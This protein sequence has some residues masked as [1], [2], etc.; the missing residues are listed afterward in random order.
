VLRTLALVAVVAACGQ[1][2]TPSNSKA[3]EA[4]ISIALYRHGDTSYG[5]VDDR[6]WVDIA[7]SSILLGNID[8]GAALASLVIESTDPSVRIGPCTRERMPDERDLP[9]APSPTREAYEEARRRA[10]LEAERDMPRRYRTRRPTPAVR[11]PAVVDRYAPIVQCDVAGPPGRYLVRIVYVSTQLAYRVHNEIE[12]KDPSKAWIE[13][14]FALATPPWRG[15]ADVTLFDGVP[16]GIEP[17]KEIIRGTVTLDGGTSV[18]VIPGREQPAQLRRVFEGLAFGESGEQ[19]YNADTM[20]VWATLEV[21]NVK[22]VRGMTRVHVELDGED[23]WIDLPAPPMKSASDEVLD[24]EA[25]ID[26]DADKPLRIKLWID[27]DLRG[28]RQRMII[29]NDGE[30]M[31]EMIALSMSNTGDTERE[32]WLEE[33]ARPAKKRSV[34]RA[35]PKKPSARGDTLRTKMIVKPRKIERAGYTLVYEL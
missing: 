29:D 2:A 5:V 6:R 10:I 31:I 20:S 32:V 14:R 12:I 1:R 3:P 26:D 8:P 30:R 18:L 16:G 4:G 24:R 19:D 28:A 23:R 7:G 35:W 17:P 33:H 15:T 9:T 25:G 11:E 27:S 21:P 13:S 22:L 34:E